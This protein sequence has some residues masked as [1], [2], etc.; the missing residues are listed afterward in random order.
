[1][2]PKLKP[3]LKSKFKAFVAALIASAIISPAVYAQAENMYICA[4]YDEGGVLV[5][6][7]AFNESELRSVLDSLAPE[8]AEKAK[9]FQWNDTLQP[10]GEL[11]V[12]DY[13][14]EADH[15]LENAE[16]TF[17]A[18]NVTAEMHTAEF[19]CGKKNCSTEPIMSS[20][21]IAELNRAILDKP[22]TYTNDL[23]AIEG[24]YNGVELAALNADFEAPKVMYLNGEPV[25]ESYYEDMRKNIR[26]SRVTENMPYK[27]GFAVNR[28]VMK[29]YPYEDYLSDDPSDPE[30]DNFVSS[31]VAVN[32][33]LVLLF[34][35]ADG[36]FI[37]AK[38]QCCSGWVPTADI[39]VCAN[40]SEWEKYKNPKDIL[41]VTGEK[42]YLE[43]S[44]DAD[45][46]EKMLTMGTVLPLVTDENTGTV[47]YRLPWGNYVVKMPAR[48]A[49]G[50]F[51][52]KDALI[53]A[54]RDVNVGYLP[55]TSANVV[56]QAFKSLGNR[57]GWGGMMNSQ[58]CS[59][60]VR[61]VYLCFGLEIPRNTTWQA[62]IPADV[63]NMSNMTDDEKTGVLNTLPTGA[64]LIFPGHEMLYLGED[65]GLYYT[66]N[67]ISSLVPP[68]SPGEIIKPRSVVVNDLST[69]RANGSTWLENLSYAVVIK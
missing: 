40:K 57:Y 31:A 33:P 2:N 50:S 22:E 62:E 14:S 61:E 41:V 66:I 25:P 49:D 26:G 29:A 6:A 56:T 59:A 20:E 54:N 12:S 17:K 32:E 65:N 21:E 45:L 47:S 38:S 63:T 58:D 55:Y 52:Q 30:W 43:P 36:K 67:D 16:N 48:K 1:M 28:T 13:T 53:P 39:A 42:V 4:Y 7:Q 35:T 23:S 11:I 27:Y 19:W 44:A 68:D 64:I 60:Y 3:K 34:T 10:V 9:L 15:E 46:N 24:T 5:D 51:Y 18:P 8:N 37:M 69:L